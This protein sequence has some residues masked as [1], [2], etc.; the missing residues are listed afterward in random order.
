MA[1]LIAD[2]ACVD[3][4]AEIDDD[5][6]VGPYCVIGPGA[7]IGKGTRLVAHVCIA[8]VTIIGKN[9]VFS[10]F[11]SIGGEPQDISYKGT[12]TR[13][14]IGDDNVFRESVTINRGTEKEEGVTRVGS[15]N[16]LMTAAH[17][18]HD[19]N[20]GDHITIANGTM[21][22]GHV[23]VES[24]AGISGAVAVHHYVTIGGY[25]FVGGLSRIYHDVPRFML[26]DGNPSKVRC[27]NVV[28]LKRS[29]LEAAVPALHEAH[30]LVFRAKMNPD[31]AAQVLESHGNL[32]PEVNRLLDF[33]RDRQTGKHG[34]MREKMRRT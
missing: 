8:G 27:I 18:A 5:V 1:V 13:V 11:C 34:R 29:G 25:S 26:V 15:R 7:R 14:E 6:E 19:C 4:R 22:G 23:H 2:T 24:H 16:Y 10:P 21:L 12:P 32:T 3:P 30:R 33:L 9:N 17:V 20:L 31:Q 28:G